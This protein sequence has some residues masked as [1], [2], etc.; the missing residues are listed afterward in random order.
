MSRGP[1]SGLDKYTNCLETGERKPTILDIFEMGNEDYP[2][3]N[4]NDE[5]VAGFNL[6]LSVYSTEG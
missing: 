3:P 4:F 2:L 5:K 6:C 1:P